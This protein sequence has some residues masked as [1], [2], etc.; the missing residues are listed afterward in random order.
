M[1]NPTLDFVEVVT[2]IDGS[3][4]NM[5]ND[6]AADLERY[7]RRRGHDVRANIDPNDE[8]HIEIHIQSYWPL[9]LSWIK[10]LLHA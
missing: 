1:S 8:Q 3:M 4:T 2:D 7:L 5:N 6:D 9:W 10:R